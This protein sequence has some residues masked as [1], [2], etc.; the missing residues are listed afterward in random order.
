[1]IEPASD[2]L[3]KEV[4][5]SGDPIL[6][7]HGLG[8]S[9]YSW[10]NFIA[11]FSEKNKLVLIDSRGCG[12]SPKP[13]DRHYSLAEKV[14][15]IYRVI[16]EENLTNLTLCGNSLGGAIAMLLAIRLQEQD[17]A[18]L[19]RLVL[20]GSAGDRRYLPPHFKF[21]RSVFGAPALYLAPSSVG[22]RAVLR[23]CYYDRKKITRADVAAYAG[24]LGSPGG[25]NALLQTVRQC[26]PPNADELL[27]K[28][29]DIRV[30]TLIIW[31]REDKIIPLKVGEILHALI[32]NSTLAIIEKCGHVPQ[33]EKPAETIQLIARFLAANPNAA[34]ELN[35]IA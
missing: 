22:A 1:V 27:A 32:P 19:A 20:I 21:V 13:L 33:E 15:E 30:P 8:A 24:P 4:Y 12:K 2:E 9:V 6:C 29:K 35:S 16:K 17:P 18:R 25:R 5:G 23:L 26:I 14:D 3:Y 34:N 28:A 11:P 31:G 10:R 7:I